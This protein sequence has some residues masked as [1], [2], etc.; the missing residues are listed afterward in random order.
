MP[1]SQSHKGP[2]RLA[3]LRLSLIRTD[4]GTQS[5]A[6]INGAT[7]AEYAERMIAGDRF[8]PV[9]VFRSNGT[10]LLADGFHRFLARRLAK[11]ERIDA[12]VRQGTRLDALK[13]SLSANHQH[14]LRRTNEDKRYAITV[15]LR[16]FSRLS[17]R[18]IADLCG[19]AHASV[20]A[21]RGQLVNLTSCQT[22]LGR[23]GKLRKLPVQPGNGGEPYPLP[24]EEESA[25]EITLE[26]TEKFAAGDC[27][28]LLPGYSRGC[29]NLIFT[30]PPYPEKRT[31]AYGGIRGRDYVAWFL[32][33]SAQFF[34]VLNPCGSFVLNIKEGVHNGERQTYV[35]ELVLALRKQGW[36]WTEEYI[37]HKRNCFPGK[38]PNRFRDAW[39][40][41][42]HFTK[43]QKFYMNQDAVMVPIGDW[44]IN[45]LKNLSAADMQRDNSA[46]G[47]GFGKYVSKWVGGKKASP[48]N[49]IHLATE[50][51]NK[52]HPAA[53]PIELPTWFI[54][55]F[56]KPGD[57]VLDP[58]IGS[59][60]TAIAAKRLHRHFL[61]FDL[62]PDYG[63][64]ALRRLRKNT[65]PDRGELR[66][67]A[68]NV[69]QPSGLLLN[70]DENLKNSI[71]SD[72]PHSH[73]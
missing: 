21:V 56:T 48:T 16:E 39:E 12:E 71:W 9:V 28:E 59:G 20:A 38:W 47:S 70:D 43:Q 5:R 57:L 13:F 46:V 19:V 22:R 25:H 15:A 58:F 4:A 53:F 24:G 27:L 63:K 29:A 51:G 50:C 35:L 11:F 69:L 30:S 41:C 52:A 72:D 3:R 37:W 44:A 40:H 6:A 66:H 49:V 42:Y 45:R 54:K 55:L 33:R 1:R 18:M 34:R 36:L 2:A 64:L 17:D 32:A 23:D 61:G 31:A 60:T 14:G 68:V 65:R 7:V 8:P 10:Y 73:H 67:D 62:S 26:V